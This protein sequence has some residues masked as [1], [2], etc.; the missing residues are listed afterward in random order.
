MGY[1]ESFKYDIFISYS[2]I[3]NE[4][5]PGTTYSWIEMFYEEL[6]LSLWQSIGT[7]KIDIWWDNKRLDG[8]VAFDGA[9]EKGI[10]DSAIFLCLNS[11][12]FLN[13]DYCQKELDLFYKKAH[14]EPYGIKIKD[15]PRIVNVLL[16]NI[17]YTR[18]PYEL[19]GTTGFAFHDG[20]DDDDNGDPVL[21]TA[22]DYKERLHKL[23]DSL[24]EL[25][26]ILRKPPPPPEEKFTIYFGEVPDTLRSLRSKT[27][28]ALKESDYAIIADIPPPYEDEEHE[29]A[30]NEALEN[31][32]LSIH[33][34]DQYP[35]KP[36]LLAPETW[37]TKKQAELSLVSAKNKFI[38]VPG[39]INLDEIEEEPYKRFLTDL[40]SGAKTAP[41][42]D[43][44]KGVKS[45]L[46]NQVKDIITR[47]IKEAM[48]APAS[49]QLSVL[50]D[51]HVKDQLYALD[52]YKTMLEKNIQPYINPQDDDPHKNINLL[53]DRI[54]VV[55]KLI[56]FYGKVSKDWVIERMNAALQVIVANNYAVDDFFVFML[57]PHKDNTN[58]VL[59]QRFVKVNV[60]NYSDH[61][62]P[63]GGGLDD[64]INT[65]KL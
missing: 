52:L 34:L 17:P 30:V 19:N 39:Q 46:T 60:F 9:I 28:N 38:W 31:A 40:D 58:F 59:K 7:K 26:E 18:W 12:S 63:D 49:G 54:S 36:I 50:L 25:I 64:F 21:Y 13:S 2:H 43:F 1:I 10:K 56:F 44:V 42:L 15:R 3:D 4:K 37:Y 45:E 35:G 62:N 61:L 33:L 65:L 16:Y 51:T 48:P 27:I 55:S 5:T 20:K 29:N 47:I 6:T 11:P 14:D 23:R 22:V 41:N 57:P 8:G 32:D 53:E 24:I